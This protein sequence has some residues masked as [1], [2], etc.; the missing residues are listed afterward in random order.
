MAYY[1][2]LKEDDDNHEQ[3]HLV[4]RR[5]RTKRC[6]SIGCGGL[7]LLGAAAG[8]MLWPQQPYI[9]TLKVENLGDAGVD[10]QLCAHNPNWVYG[11]QLHDI[12]ASTWWIPKTIV[13]GGACAPDQESACDVRIQERCAVPIAESDRNSTKRMHVS[14]RHE[15]CIDLALVPRSTQEAACLAQMVLTKPTSSADAEEVV[16]IGTAKATVANTWSFGGRGISR[17]LNVWWWFHDDDG[18]EHKKNDFILTYN[19]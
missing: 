15:D 8:F 4:Q 16:V 9:T 13:V 1:S 2:P 18:N 12:R 7:M 6:A 5:Q 14:P 11:S 10:L 17:E 3:Q 19:T